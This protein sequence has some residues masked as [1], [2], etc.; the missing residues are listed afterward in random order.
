MRAILPP[1][2]V[3]ITGCSSGIGYRTARHLQDLG[4][5]VIATA[6]NQQDVDAL[7]GEFNAFR[8]DLD[9]PHSI[10]EALEAIFALT[11][12]RLSAVFHNGAFGLPGA[13]EDISRSALRRQFETNVF[14][15]HDLNVRLIAHFRRQG[16]GRI[17]FN[18]SILGF[19]A[20]AYR[21]AYNASKYAIEGMADT[22]RLELHGTDIRVVLIEPGPIESRFR[23]NAYS[24]FQQ[25]VQVDN[26]AHQ[27][28]YQAM[29]ARLSAS[30]KTA[31]FTLPAQ[32]VAEVVAKALLARNPKARYP[33]TLPTKVFAWL[34]R[35]LPTFLLDVA[36]RRAG[37]S[38]KR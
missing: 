16:Y 14:G 4:Y 24:A 13:L 30:E 20:M 35:L 10:E 28:Q 29:I 12:H 36:L 11:S 15:T 26:S 22:L 7:Q 34:K 2:P 21:G 23:A 31:P 18:S 3:L 25:W 5:H 8:L 32:A 33:V 17:I 6:R 1:E 37:G 9:D 38:G 19:A 27:E